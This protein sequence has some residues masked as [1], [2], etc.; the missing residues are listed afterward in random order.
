[1]K[2]LPTKSRHR[3]QIQV[4]GFF[5]C[6]YQWAITDFVYWKSNTKDDR[7]W[8]CRMRLIQQFTPVKRIGT[9]SEALDRLCERGMGF[10]KMP[11]GK[12]QRRRCGDG[13]TAEP[14]QSYQYVFDAKVFDA[15]LKSQSPKP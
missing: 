11:F 7:R 1:M 2:T 12:P 13:L 14:V 5:N 3:L 8:T 6:S 9:I 15:W 4:G 10:S